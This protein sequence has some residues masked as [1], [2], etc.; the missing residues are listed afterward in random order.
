[1]AEGG[2]TYKWPRPSLTVDAVIVAAPEGGSGAQLLL[3]QASLLCAGCFGG[4]LIQASCAAQADAMC[5][6]IW[7]CPHTQQLHLIT[8]LALL[9]S[10]LHAAQARPFCVC[11][12]A[13][14]RVCG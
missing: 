11:L 12:G 8:A 4:L 2:H 9:A 3:I 7:A 1:M 6:L 5:R 13:A 14:G 10:L